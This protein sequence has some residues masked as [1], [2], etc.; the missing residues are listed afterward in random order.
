HRLGPGDGRAARPPRAS[1][2]GGRRRRLHRAAAGAAAPLRRSATPGGHEGLSGRLPD[3]RRHLRAL[4]SAG[5]ADAAAAGAGAGAV[6]RAPGRRD[7]LTPVGMP[8]L[9]RFGRPG[10]AWPGVTVSGI[11]IVAAAV[12]A[13]AFG[14]PPRGGPRLVIGLVLGFVV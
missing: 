9:P 5:L 14:E 11:V 2:R 7:G 8:G 10:D 1:L 4:R 13:D 3:S 12:L 6:R